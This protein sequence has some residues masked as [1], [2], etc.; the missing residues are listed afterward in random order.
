ML[1]E[2]HTSRPRQLSPRPTPLPPPETCAATT[3]ALGLVSPP[4]AALST[5]PYLL[6][7]IFAY[8]LTANYLRTLRVTRSPSIRYL[9][10]CICTYILPTCLPDTTA[11]E[12]HLLLPAYLFNYLTPSP[13][14]DAARSHTLEAH[15]LTYYLLICL[16]N[17][18]IACG[19][20]ER[21]APNTYILAHSLT[22]I[23]T[24]L[25]S[26]RSHTCLLAG[27]ARTPVLQDVPIYL[28]TCSL[29]Y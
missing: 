1:T 29:T 28:F 22:C 20:Q 21:P 15:F 25:R 27:A 26:A 8:I 12:H 13:Q 4:P 18:S 9:L 14:A 16:H 3:D 11:N 10:T 23:P 6:A 5:Y 2:V 19:R 24:Y 7:Y 17:Y